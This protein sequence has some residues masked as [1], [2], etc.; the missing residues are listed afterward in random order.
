MMRWWPCQRVSSRSVANS[1]WCPARN[2]CA[3]SIHDSYANSRRSTDANDGS[4]E[5]PSFP[6]RVGWRTAWPDMASP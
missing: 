1:V 3:V 2:P 4:N 6:S 5:G